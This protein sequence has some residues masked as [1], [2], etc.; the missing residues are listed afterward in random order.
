MAEKVRYYLEQTVPELQDLQKK[1]IFNKQEIAAIMKR[2]TDF[3]HRIGSRGVKPADFLRYVEYEMNL[4]SLRRKRI[5]RMNLKGR[6]SVSDWAGKRRILF[7]FDRG[8]KRFPSEISLW[9][10]Y[11]EYAK[12]ADAVNV[13]TKIFTTVLRLHPTNASLWIMAAQHEFE[14]NANVRAARSIMQRG[15]R[16]A[17]HSA[18]LWVEYAKLELNYLAKVLA[19]RQILGIDDADKTTDEAAERLRDDDE[20]AS[21]SIKLPTST[22]E[23][24]RDDLRALPDVDISVLGSLDTNPALNGAVVEAVMDA[25]AKAVPGRELAVKLLELVDS[26]PFL[27]CQQRLVDHVADALYAADPALQANVLVYVKAPT[28]AV[29]P[30]VAAFPAALQ[31]SLRRFW[32]AVDGRDD[33]KAI[34]DDYAAGLGQFLAFPS[35][36]PALEKAIKATQVKIARRFP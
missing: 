29:L 33:A 31:T 19:R 15:L 6:S 16:F 24:V 27:A 13:L 5:Q 11:V 23:E 12:Q 22:A 36:D 26:F 20:L 30:S 4:D 8:T 1:G 9:T 18:R 2:R 7:V 25:A 3:E 21:D 32:A 14:V 34:A 10:E 17:S 28:R 35:L